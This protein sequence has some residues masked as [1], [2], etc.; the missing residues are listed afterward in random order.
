MSQ[1]IEAFDD[2]FFEVY[3]AHHS[4]MGIGHKSQRILDMKV[5]H[6][7]KLPSTLLLELK[8]QYLQRN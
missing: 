4:Q 1:E 6:R 3:E 8:D 7:S 2:S 5:S